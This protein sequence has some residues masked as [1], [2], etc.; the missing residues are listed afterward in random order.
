MPFVVAQAAR[1]ISFNIH[2]VEQQ[3]QL[4]DVIDAHAELRVGKILTRAA[5]VAGA[6]GGEAVGGNHVV[7][8]A[9]VAAV[10]HRAGRFHTVM[11]GA[12]AAVVAAG[13]DSGRLASGLAGGVDHPAGGVTVQGGKRPAQHLERIEA[14]NINIRGLPLAIGHGGR[15]TVDVN[16]QPA[17][18]VGGAG[19]EAA[20]R[21]LQILR[22]VLAVLHLQSRYRAQRLGEV[23]PRRG[24]AH[25]IAVNHANGGGGIE[26]R[27]RRRRGGNHHGLFSGES[28]WPCGDQR[29]K[30]SGERGGAHGKD[31]H[32]SYS[33]NEPNGT[34]VYMLALL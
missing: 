4:T 17:H 22:V 30:Q 6:V 25:L 26:F 13:F 3:G 16:T 31:F 19:P 27:N 5:M 29:Q 15:D 34:Y 14:A 24:L 8:V 1:V 10:A 9:R 20:N 18:A 11:P 32:Q 21:K 33:Q 28:G 2:A 23:Y 7:D 12:K